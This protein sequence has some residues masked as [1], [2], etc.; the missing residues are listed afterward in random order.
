[1]LNEFKIVP[2]ITL[3]LNNKIIK[4]TILKVVLSI[5]YSLNLFQ[6]YT[7]VPIIY[8]KYYYNLIYQFFKH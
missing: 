1:M 3:K 7:Y 8:L 5:L 4:F 2:K 6:T